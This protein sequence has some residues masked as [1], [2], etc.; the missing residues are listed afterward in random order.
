MHVNEVVKKAVSTLYLLRQLKRANV[1]PVD[2]LSFFVTCIRPVMEYACQVFHKSLPAYLSDEL[3][4]V[5]QRRAS[6]IIYPDLS[7]AAALEK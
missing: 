1:A 5:I 3:E 4:K 2:L 6:R 7:Y